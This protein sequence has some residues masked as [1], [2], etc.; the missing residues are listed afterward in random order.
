MISAVTTPVV[1][2]EI[3]PSSRIY[4]QPI[5]TRMCGLWSQFFIG[6][7]YQ[8]NFGATRSDN[9]EAKFNRY[10]ALPSRNTDSGSRRIHDDFVM[11]PFIDISRT[12]EEDI[13]IIERRMERAMGQMKSPGLDQD[14]Y[15]RKYTREWRDENAHSKTY[16]SESV[17]IMRPDNSI[18]RENYHGMGHIGLIAAGIAAVSW[19]QGTKRF[20]KMYQYSTFSVEYRWKLV[21]LWP[22]LL[23][24]SPKFRDG[25]ENAVARSKKEALVKPASTEQ[26][27]EH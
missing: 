24:T 14:S 19:Y 6:R 16:F 12:I 1:T 15:G 3:T 7:M 18:R 5:R 8:C 27:D 22:I 2:L 26:T 20:L 11:D 21:L 10:G 9:L 4:P 25:W 23:L 17:T 13:N